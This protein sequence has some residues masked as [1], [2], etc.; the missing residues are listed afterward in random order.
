VTFLD[1]NGASF[2]GCRSGGW[3]QR[4]CGGYCFAMRVAVNREGGGLN[5]A[6]CFRAGDLF[7]PKRGFVQRM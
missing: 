1:R 3:W 5:V 2:N 6:L 4:S 7:R